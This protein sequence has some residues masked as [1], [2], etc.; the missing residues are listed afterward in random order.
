MVMF[1]LPVKTKTQRLH[2]TQ[3]RQLLLDCGYQMV[4]FSVYARFSP[5]SASMLPTVRRIKSGLPHGGDVRIV[6]ITDHQWATA[7]RFSSGTTA[8]VEDAPLQLTIF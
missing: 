5:S 7:L 1:D 2:A 6:S 3:F 8:E 4:Q